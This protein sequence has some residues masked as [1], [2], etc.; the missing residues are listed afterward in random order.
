MVRVAFHN[1][2]SAPGRISKSPTCML[3][4]RLLTELPLKRK[5]SD[6]VT[7]LKPGARKAVR[8]RKTMASPL[9]PAS[10]NGVPTSSESSTDTGCARLSSVFKWHAV[11]GR[12]SLFELYE[13]RKTKQTA[14]VRRIYSEVLITR[15]RVHAGQLFSRNLI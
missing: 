9:A 4:F 10:S 14:I 6:P 15:T 5:I 11:C 12:G 8:Y 13:F 7:A 2:V 3:R 1:P